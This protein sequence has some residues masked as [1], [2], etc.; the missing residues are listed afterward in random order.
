MSLRVGLS[1]QPRAPRNM[2]QDRR[3]GRTTIYMTVFLLGK[4][5][6]AQGR[7]AGRKEGEGKEIKPN[8]NTP[9]PCTRLP[10]GSGEVCSLES[11]FLCYLGDCNPIIEVSK[12]RLQP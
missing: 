8:R 4:C 10:P 3:R 7:G 12:V 5:G 11:L 1:G 9:Q 2:R 6:P